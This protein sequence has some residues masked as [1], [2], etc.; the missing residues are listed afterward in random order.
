MLP[1]PLERL[2]RRVDAGGLAR[3]ALERIEREAAGV[4]VDVEHARIFRQRRHPPPVLALI[5]EHAGLLSVQRIDRERDAVLDAAYAVGRGA[6]R[7]VAAHHPRRR[8]EAFDLREAARRHLDDRLGLHDFRER[9]VELDLALLHP[10]R[11]ELH[12]AHVAVDV[13]DDARQRVALGVDEPERVGRRRREPEP[14]AQSERLG[15]A[16]RDQRRVDGLVA[17]RHHAHA[18]LRARID[19]AAPDVAPLRVGHVDDIAGLIGALLARDGARINPRMA[20][21]QRVGPSALEVHRRHGRA[22][23]HNNDKLPACVSFGS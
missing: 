16:P 7:L 13:D 18:N 15:H 2:A 17:P 11:R 4:G 12:R 23:Y 14:R 6:R 1:H 5:E 9:V 20:L 19:E 3:A 21:P 22:T 8:R 10:E